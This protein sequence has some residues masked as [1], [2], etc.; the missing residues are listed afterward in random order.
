LVNA[1]FVSIQ[2]FEDRLQLERQ[3][4]SLIDPGDS[5][6]GG[7]A[8]AEF[9]GKS[10]PD[11]NLDLVRPEPVR[12]APL[13]NLLVGASFRGALHDLAVLKIKE[14]REA[15]IECL[16]AAKVFPI[17]FRQLFP[18]VEP[19][20]VEHAAEIDETANLVAGTAE[21]MMVHIITLPLPSVNATLAT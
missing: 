4:D 18:Q 16:G 3:A 5:S 10:I 9:L 11:M 6:P 8:P 20:L 15:P 17:I 19:D 7:I 14:A 13:Q 1:A 2:A 21:R 12:K